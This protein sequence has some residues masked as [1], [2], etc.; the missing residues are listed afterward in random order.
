MDV[1]ERLISTKR[2]IK[3][4]EN[5]DG[6]E[7]DEI[8]NAFRRRYRKLHPDWEVLFLSL[9]KQDQ[10]KRLAEKKWLVEFLMKQ[11]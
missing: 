8:L 6:Y 4:I 10:Q 7:I 11:E 9:P 3:R 2:L 1:L 5:A